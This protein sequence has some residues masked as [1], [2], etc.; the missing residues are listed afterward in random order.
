MF[1]RF[2][3]ALPPCLL[4]MLAAGLLASQPV[5]AQQPAPV[6]GLVPLPREVKTS[7]GAYA[8]P[9]KISIYAVGKD[10]LNVAGLLKEQLLPLGHTVTLTTNRQ[11]AQIK[12]LTAPTPHPE[13]YQLVVDAAGVRITAAGG[14][15]LF[16]GAQTLLQLLPPQPRA[17]AAVPY[18]RISDEPAFGWR[19]AHLDVS[20]HFFSVAFIKKYIDFLAAYK[21]NTFHWHLTDDQGW[22]LEIKK[23]PKLTQVSAF[24]QQTLIGAQQ[25]FKTPA[26]FKYDATPY[27]GF[28]TQAQVREVVAYAQRR[29]VTIVPEIEMPG[30]SVAILAAYPEL[31]CRPGPYQVWQ[32]WGVNEDIVCPSEATFQFFENVLAEVTQLFPG[33]YVHI[34]GDEAPKTRWKESALVQDIMK[35]ESFTDVEQVQGWFNRRIEKYLQSKGKKLIGWD[36]V[37]EGGI[38]PSATIMSWRGEKGGIE[39]AQKGHDVVMTPTTYVYFDYGQ[40]PQVHSPYEPLYIGGYLPLEK[41]YGYH[42]LPA[43][44]T[45]AQQQHILGVQGNL[46]T[47]YV[48]TPAKA[49]YMLLPRMLALAEVAWTPAARRAYP[50]FLPRLGQQY[51]RLDQKNINYRVPEPL[52]LDS[53]SVVRQGGKAVFTLR[54]LVPGGQVHYTLDG[55]LPDATSDRYTKPLAVPVGERLTVR[56]VTV[57]PNGRNSPPAELLVK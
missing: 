27:G 45:P 1:V 2:F 39:A 34:G 10:A 49:E 6:L 32:M 37:L 31:A 56:A 33:R 9:Q 40:N 19:G 4:S 12:L 8:L 5:L 30:H 52:G 21:L 53:A 23:Y 50:D 24:R 51:A 16:Y 57:A 29:Y 43:E 22:R 18:V 7:A 3:R 42:P 11:A 55:T 17:T 13:G 46:W 35:K 38:S 20:R 41:V 25:L 15:G 54:S 48:T 26:E 47:E 36:E 44:L 14:A 28:Y